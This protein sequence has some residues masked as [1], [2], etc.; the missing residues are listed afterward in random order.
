M[1]RKIVIETKTFEK[2]GDATKFFKDILNS[3][4]IGDKV[5][6]QDALHLKALLDRHD[7]K[8][9][10]IGAGIS[11]FEVNLPP[12]DTPNNFSKR[13]FWIIRTDGTKIDFSYPHCLKKKPYD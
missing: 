4:N 3:Y 9:D 11:G 5:S 10:K 1:V 8:E 7:E 6:D 13:C 12:E 2:A